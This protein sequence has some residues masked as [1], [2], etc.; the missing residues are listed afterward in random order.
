MGDGGAREISRE[1]EQVAGRSE[2]YQYPPD[3][4][5]PVPCERGTHPIQVLDRFVLLPLGNAL[6][7]ARPSSWAYPC[8][9]FHEVL[10]F[11]FGAI[12]A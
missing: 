10:S 3:F 7:L 4:R 12:P 8:S 11:R 5:I 9:I 1:R 2:S 6:N